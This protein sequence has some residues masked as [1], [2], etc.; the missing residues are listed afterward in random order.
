[1]EDFTNTER[2]SGKVTYY[3]TTRWTLTKTESEESEAANEP[4]TVQFVDLTSEDEDK[5]DEE[6]SE[7]ADRP[8]QVELVDLTNG[9]STE[10]D[11][12]EG[13]E[14]VDEGDE[15]DEYCGAGDD[16]MGRTSIRVSHTHFY[17]S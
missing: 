14:Y 10:E 13:S 12:D 2:I 8:S 6:R 3:S 5:G 1:M 16:I 7:A 15:S 9:E 11:T 4:K 17:L